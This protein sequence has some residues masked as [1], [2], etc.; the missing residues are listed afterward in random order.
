MF[1]AHRGASQ[2]THLLLHDVK[3]VREHPECPDL[4]QHESEEHVELVVVSADRDGEPLVVI[5][6]FVRQSGEARVVGQFRE[7]IL[8]EVNEE[9]GIMSTDMPQ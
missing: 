8:D 4:L 9:A 5:R 6:Y 2:A 1:S 7:S 3:P